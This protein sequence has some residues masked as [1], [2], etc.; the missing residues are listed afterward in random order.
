MK[1][2]RAPELSSDGRDGKFDL[3]DGRFVAELEPTT[4]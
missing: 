2:Q 1:Y 4:D 3:D